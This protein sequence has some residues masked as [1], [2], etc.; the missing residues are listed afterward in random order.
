MANESANSWDEDAPANTDNISDGAQ[1]MRY[2]RQA[3]ADTFEYEHE[4]PTPSSG[5]TL[6]SDAGR[7]LQGSAVSYSQDSEPSLR[8]DESTSFVDGE[9]Q[10][11][12]WHDSDDSVFK[13]LTAVD[14]NVWTA[15]GSL[16]GDTVE[17]SGATATATFTDSD[18][19]NPEGRFRVQAAG[20]NLNLDYKSGESTFTTLA[21]LDGSNGAL[22]LV[23]AMDA[24]SQKI[25]DLADGTESGDALHYGQVDDST[26]GFNGSDQLEVKDG[27]VQQA[28]ISSPFGSW[29]DKA[30]G[31]ESG[32]VFDEGEAGFLLCNI[33]SSANED[34]NYFLYSDDTA[35]P[36][37]VLYSE[38]WHAD[39]MGEYVCTGF[40]VPIKAGDK[41][42]LVINSGY[43][44]RLIW[45]PFGVA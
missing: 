21:R 15:I 19:S 18:E 34:V 30:P 4:S 8:P 12:L 11:R 29:T 6:P 31:W 13:V 10:G 40:C 38:V 1:E 45:L 2:L 42:K 43:L 41:W 16:V 20:T 44:E 36:S 39:H 17:I 28:Q 37:T 23:A 5:T 32:D 14:S 35:D 3:V 7:H 24:N 26:I 22:Q 33:K 27:S 9:D 25:T